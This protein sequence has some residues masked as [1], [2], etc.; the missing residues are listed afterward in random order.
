MRRLGW[1]VRRECQSAS[2]EDLSVRDWLDDAAG[3][4]AMKRVEAA[5]V[6][7]WWVCRSRLLIL[8]SNE[9]VRDRDT[10][11]P[12][13]LDPFSAFEAVQE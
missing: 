10:V 1:S 9:W 7:P 12:L 13:S 4:L 5:L 11:G 3:V 8:S 2:Q 6:H